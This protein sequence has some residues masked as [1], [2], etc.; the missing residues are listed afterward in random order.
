MINLM[1]KRS[2]WRIS[3]TINSRDSRWSSRPFTKSITVTI[4][5]SFYPKSRKYTQCSRIW[6]RNTWQTSPWCGSMKS[7]TSLKILSFW[8]NF[9]PI[10]LRIE[11]WWRRLCKTW[12]KL[13]KVSI[14]ELS[15]GFKPV[16][17][18]CQLSP[19]LHNVKHRCN[20]THTTNCTFRT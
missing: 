14:F 11:N 12:I 3:F 13:M 7:S 6:W 9:S 18:S 2:S 1:R 15:R 16:Q 19:L 4:W 10:T 20:L 17:S 5:H 8:T